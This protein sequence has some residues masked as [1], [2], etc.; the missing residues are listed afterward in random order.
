MGLFV[1]HTHA[2]SSYVWNGT[3]TEPTPT[4]SGKRGW[5]D[6]YN[7]PSTQKETGPC[8]PTPCAPAPNEFLAVQLDIAD[9][10]TEGLSPLV[11]LSR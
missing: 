6:V 7:T 11:F 9:G 4:G 1:G 10:A 3:A 2:A 5:L 8:N